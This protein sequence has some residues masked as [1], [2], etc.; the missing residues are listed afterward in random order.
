MMD[1]LSKGI[2]GV[3]LISYSNIIDERGSF[4]QVFSGPL[5]VTKHQ[6]IEFNVKEVFISVSKQNVIRGMHLQ[7]EPYCSSK[8]VIPWSGEVVDVLIDL[9][10]DSKTYLNIQEFRLIS[11]D[12]NMLYV[13]KGV[14]HGFKV[15]SEEA[16]LIYLSDEIHHKELDISI[17][18]F[19]LD[20]DWKTTIPIISKRDL[21]GISLEFF[22][23]NYEVNK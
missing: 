21:N 12:K 22:I 20:Y 15:I 5:L 19:S 3:Y 17:N 4:S 6:S 9:R 23:S 18:P 13:P 11:T 16:T 2:D 1:K 14:A 7:I 8:L 10:S